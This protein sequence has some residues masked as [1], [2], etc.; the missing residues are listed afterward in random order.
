MIDIEW[1][2]YLGDDLRIAT[3]EDLKETE[4]RI[5]RS[6]PDALKRIIQKHGGET[7]LNL[8]PQHPDGRPMTIECIYHAH[9]NSTDYNSYTIPSATSCLEDEGYADLTA[10]CDTENVFLCLDYSVRDVNP[11][12][13]LVN[14]SFMPEDPKHKHVLADNFEAF[15]EKY[16][17]PMNA[18]D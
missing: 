17:V 8:I 12:V 2:A 4:Q 1:E 10:F 18:V 9:L 3:A 16:T 7:P 5:N 13:V 6:L 11:P 14:R 15:L